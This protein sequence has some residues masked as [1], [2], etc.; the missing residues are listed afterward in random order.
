MSRR[1][2][3]GGLLPEVEITGKGVTIGEDTNTVRPTPAGWNEL[4]RL[5]NC[6]AIGEV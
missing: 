1:R 5:I 6:E 4:V 2:E 3:G